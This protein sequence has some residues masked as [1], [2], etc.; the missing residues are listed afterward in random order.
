VGKIAYEGI[1]EVYH[2]PSA[3]GHAGRLKDQMVSAPKPIENRRLK[4][5]MAIN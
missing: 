2:Q 1:S 4:L 5:A 3:L